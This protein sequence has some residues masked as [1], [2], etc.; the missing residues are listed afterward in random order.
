MILS[1]CINEREHS[2]EGEEDTSSKLASRT[3][4]SRRKL[5]AYFDGIDS[6]QKKEKGCPLP[7]GCA[8]RATKEG[9]V[10]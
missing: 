9:G 1:P 7:E 2:S 10:D 5:D 4:M 3:S 6:L 8:E